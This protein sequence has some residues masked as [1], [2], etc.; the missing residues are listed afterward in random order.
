M[1]TLNTFWGYVTGIDEWWKH[2]FLKWP[3]DLFLLTASLLQYSGIYRHILIHNG[4]DY[5]KNIKKQSDEWRKYLSDQFEYEYKTAEGIPLNN[6]L[7]NTPHDIESSIKRLF[8][9]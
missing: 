7:I 1:K 5:Q 4:K 8:Y 6:Q 2:E 9:L 3:P